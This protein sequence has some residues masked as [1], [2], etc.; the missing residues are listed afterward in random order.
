MRASTAGV[1]DAAGT[2]WYPW[3]GDVYLRRPGIWTGSLATHTMTGRFRVM[4]AG[5]AWFGSPPSDSDS[6]SIATFDIGDTAD[7]CVQ[8]HKNEGLFSVIQKCKTASNELAL[9]ADCG[10]PGLMCCSDQCD[11]PYKC[12]PDIYSEWQAHICGT[13]C[14]GEGQ[15]W[16]LPGTCNSGLVTTNG[17]MICKKPVSTCHT[18]NGTC[19]S[20]ANCCTGLTCQSGT[21]KTP[22]P[23]PPPARTT[24]SY[25]LNCD[26]VDLTAGS[27][28]PVYVCQFPL[29]GTLN[30]G[31]LES[32]TNP[33]NGI[34]EIVKD[35]ANTMALALGG[36][37]SSMYTLIGAAG[38]VSTQSIWGTKPSLASGPFVFYML[39]NSSSAYYTLN[40][41]YSYVP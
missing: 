31:L 3:K 35:P 37:D 21:C 6:V 24:L 8:A 7:A 5:K 40:V 19:T 25:G 41:T 14:G 30:Q 34:V 29:T 10:K 9:K 1:T 12:Y 22:P 28:Y 26:Y 2:T 33:W 15:V 36:G 27:G 17:S 32:I 11:S 23:P 16:C 4:H 20:N 18:Q 38:T 13:A 39:A